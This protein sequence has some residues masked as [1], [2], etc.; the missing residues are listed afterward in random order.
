MVHGRLSDSLQASDFRRKSLKRRLRT[1]LDNA[2][3]VLYDTE[4]FFVC[5]ALHSSERIQSDGIVFG[6][7]AFFSLCSMLV[8]PECKPHS[9]TWLA[10]GSFKNFYAYDC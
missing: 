4:G 8:T 6:T 2:K 5:K 1:V 9:Y 3:H 7:N 10:G